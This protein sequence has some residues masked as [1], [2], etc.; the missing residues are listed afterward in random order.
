MNRLSA[1]ALA[2]A[3]IWVLSVVA[4]ILVIS[5]NPGAKGLFPILG[6]G[7]AVAIALLSV[8]NRHK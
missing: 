4:L 2:N 5:D 1:L 3:V 7:L 8:V 6:G